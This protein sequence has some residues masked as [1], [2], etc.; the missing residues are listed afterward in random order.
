M[1]GV[2]M[3]GGGIG[4]RRWPLVLLLA[5]LLVPAYVVVNQAQEG[6]GSVHGVAPKG[7]LVA[8]QGTSLSAKADDTT[9]EFKIDRVPV[10]V[11]YT[12]VATDESGRDVWIAGN[13]AIRSPGETVAIPGFTR[14]STQTVPIY[15]KEEKQETPQYKLLNP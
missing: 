11:F 14:V 9:G 12:V 3:L 8:I 10:G 2:V 5:L 13:V 15:L 6:T 1:Y 4:M 7:Y